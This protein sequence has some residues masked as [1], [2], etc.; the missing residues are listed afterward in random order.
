MVENTFH[1]IVLVG[2]NVLTYINDVVCDKLFMYYHIMYERIKK[3]PMR[4]KVLDLER[5]NENSK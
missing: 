3:Q 5:L 4:V 2:I 1:Y